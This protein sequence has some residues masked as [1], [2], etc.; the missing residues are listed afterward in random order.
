MNRA[1]TLALLLAL[2]FG[3]GVHAAPARNKPAADTLPPALVQKFRAIR[4]L[5]ADFREEKK[6]AILVAPLVRTGTLAYEAPDHLAQQTRQPSPSRMVLQG[7]RLTISEGEGKPATVIDIDKQAAVGLLVR[8]L[9]GVLA[10]DVST[11]Q[12]HARIA[13]RTLPNSKGE[14]WSLDLDPVDPLLQKLITSMRVTG[15]GAIIDVLTVIDRSGDQTVTRFSS[16]K[17]L[18][19]FSAQERAARFGS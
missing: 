18:P 3:P 8:L 19:G 1:G 5:T 16:V 13:F 4:A 12:Q 17:L 2:G 7:K 6:M 9:L 14:A 11:L 10:G 15:R